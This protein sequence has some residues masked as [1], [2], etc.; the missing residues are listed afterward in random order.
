LSFPSAS[1]APSVARRPR[2]PFFAPGRQIATVLRILAPRSQSMRQSSSRGGR[3]GIDVPG[4]RPGGVAELPGRQTARRDACDQYQYRPRQ[5]RQYPLLLIVVVV[6]ATP[7][8]IA[9]ATTAT[10]QELGVRAEGGIFILLFLFAWREA[11]GYWRGTN[12][13]K[14]RAKHLG[15]HRSQKYRYL[16]Y[17]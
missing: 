6:T 16:F 17:Y 11:S 8:P 13:P 14:R 2:R 12:T 9:A 15:V 5:G 3:E 4:Y 10:A 7:P 1:L